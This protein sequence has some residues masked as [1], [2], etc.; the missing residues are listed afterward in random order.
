MAKRTESKAVQKVEG[1]EAN[2]L[3]GY[4]DNDDSFE[5]IEEYIRIP[6]IK[7]VQGMSDE[8]LKDNFNEGSAIIR[9][10]DALIC[11]KK[12]SFDFVPLFR[13]T[14]FAKHTDLKDKG[15]RPMVV[16]SS[17][18]K[19]G[20][21]AARARDS[22][23][24]YEIYEEDEGQDKPRKYRYVEHLRFPGVIV[25]ERDLAG[26]QVVLSFEKGEFN[27]GVALLNAMR[28]RKVVVG[29]QRVTAPMYTQVWSFTPAFRDRGD[30]KWWGFDYAPAE[31]SL[32]PPTQVDEYRDAHVELKEAFNKKAIIVEGDEPDDEGDDDVSNTSKL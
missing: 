24:R 23:L 28:L 29:D 7:L 2:W 26:T 31:P 22:K 10:G 13:F 20:E 9:P 1:V 11:V 32:I 8:E 4:I 16:Q 5:G 14:E 17:F 30:K 15:K 3:Q 25:G 6:R 18:D 19:S 21:L 27:Q 12:E